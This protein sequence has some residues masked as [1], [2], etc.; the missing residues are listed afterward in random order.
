M[1]NNHN[2]QKKFTF[3]WRT[4][5][6]I[7]ILGII[8]YVLVPKLLGVRQ[9]IGLLKNMNLFWLIGALIIEFLFYFGMAVLLRVILDVL[10]QKLKFWD[11][12]RLSYLSNFA[13]HLLPLAFVGTG[14]VN[15]YFL[16]LKGLTSGQAIITIVLRNTFTYIAMAV[17][18]VISIIY[19]PTHAE[20]SRLQTYIVVG[21]IG[22]AIWLLLY[23]IYLYYNKDIFYRRAN[24]LANFLN[25]FSWRIRKKSL[26]S[27]EK[28][29]IIVDDIYEG[30]RLLDQKRSAIPYAIFGGLLNWLGDIICLGLVLL[31]FGYQVHIGVLIFAYV[32]SQILGIASWIP[33]GLGIVE[34]S[35][36]L[37]LIG[38]GAPA[39]ITWM[40]VL[41]FRLLSFW[42]PIPVGMYSFY[43][44][45]QEAKR[46]KL[47]AE[48][49]QMMANSG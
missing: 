44:L 17:L 29:K 45:S 13:M 33:G 39:E 9:A 2:N 16:K 19:L 49:G 14:I 38:F 43:S 6:F 22:F 30:F 21:L 28:T 42:L 1:N 11:L 46:E 26:S 7:L 3:N 23:M 37:I 32:I 36:G 10:N 35:L 24:Q 5:I 12:L 27:Q 8:I 25:W 34:G 15:Y 4:F 41:V 47:I 20:L 31:A 18:L 40:G 48:N